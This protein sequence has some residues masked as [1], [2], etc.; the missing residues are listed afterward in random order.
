M[1]PIVALA[2]LIATIRDVKEGPES[3]FYL[4]LMGHIHV[5]TFQQL[6]GVAVKMGLCTVEHHY[7]RFTQPAPGSKGE[8]LLKTI[9]AVEAKAA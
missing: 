3:S 1:N 9:A 8:E 7:V 2:A 4:P 5:D 6:L